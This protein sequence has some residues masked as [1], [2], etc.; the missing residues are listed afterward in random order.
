MYP[1]SNGSKPIVFVKEDDMEAIQVTRTQ[2]YQTGFTDVLNLG[3]PP[4]SNQQNPKVDP[5][6]KISAIQTQQENAK[7]TDQDQALQQL[8]D[9][10][11]ENLNQLQTVGLQFTQHKQTG[12]TVIKV[13][14]E[15]TGKVIREIPPESFLDVVAKLDQMIGILFDKRA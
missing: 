2:R 4:G 14:E 11:Q 7:N 6:E 13:V 12:R 8:R 15:K 10:L 5:V 3:Y 1:A 9:K